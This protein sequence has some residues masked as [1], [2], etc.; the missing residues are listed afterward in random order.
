[1]PRMVVDSNG[2][3]T[4]TQ[5]YAKTAVSMKTTI[6]TDVNVWLNSKPIQDNIRFLME[7][8]SI[9]GFKSNNKV[10]KITGKARIDIYRPKENISDEI[11]DSW[12]SKLSIMTRETGIEF[13]IKTLNE[14]IN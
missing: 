7:E 5:I 8:L 9:N 13:D 6:T 12:M 2:T 14:F 3:V 11:L 4:E 10:F 1:M